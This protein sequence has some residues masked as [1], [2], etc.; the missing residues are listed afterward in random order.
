MGPL[1]QLRMLPLSRHQIIADRMRASIS[2]PNLDG[3]RQCLAILERRVMEMFAKLK[4]SDCEAA[5]RPMKSPQQ[6]ANAESGAMRRET[7]V[8]AMLECCQGQ[9]TTAQPCDT[10]D[11]EEH[12]Q[13]SSVATNNSTSPS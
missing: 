12:V 1:V 13:S 3:W 11:L 8:K 5:R 6:E 9:G 7:L 10:H 4:S 2:I